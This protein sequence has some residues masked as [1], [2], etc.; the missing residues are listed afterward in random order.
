MASCEACGIVVSC[1]GGC[2]AVSASDCVDCTVWCEAFAA[3]AGDL[4]SPIRIKKQGGDGMHVLVGDEAGNASDRPKYPA[5]K[6]TSPVL[7]RHF[8]HKSRAIAEPQVSGLVA[9]C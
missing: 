9:R 8:T 1:G 6:R 5:E 7:Q 4:G 3:A 2:G